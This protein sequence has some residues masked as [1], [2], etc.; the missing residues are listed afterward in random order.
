MVCDLPQDFALTTSTLPESE[1]TAVAAA[2]EAFRRLDAAYLCA[3][4]ESATATSLTIS[5][6][7]NGKPYTVALLAVDFYGNV[8]GTYF[9]RTVTPKPVTDLWED[10]HDRDSEVEG[11]CLLAQTYGDGGPL[12]QAL[13]GFRDDTLA[14]TAFGRA[15]IDAYY[16]SL[17]RLDLHGSLVLRALAAV[18][19]APVVVIALLWH[20]LTLPGLLAVLALAI[21]LRRR[22]R[23]APRRWAAAGV[24]GAA[25]AASL[26]SPRLAAADDFTPYWQT[27]EQTDDSLLSAPEINWHA[28]IR[29][30]PYIPDVDLQAGLNATTGKGPYAAMFGNYYFESQPGSDG[31][32]A[33]G[34]LVTSPR[35]M[36]C[37][38]KHDRS[39]W[40]VLPMLDLER[41]VWDGYGQLAVGGSV[42]YMQKTSYAY[43]DDTSED[44]ALRP[45]S[46]TSKNTF[47]L[48]PLAATLSYRFTLLDDLYGI[49]V[50]PYLR[51][52]LSYYAWWIN[53]PSG[54][55]S[56]VCEM[57]N[58]DGTCAKQDKA[59]GGSL[60]FQGS[61]GLAI[62]AERID[63][64]AAM[65]MR[66]SGLKH[67]GFYAEYQYAKVDGFGAASKL[68]VG[69]NTWFAGIDFEF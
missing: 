27:D 62:R 9:D 31:T 67:A 47:K 32:C 18:A 42:G 37:S 41:V 45:R 21:A 6:L 7:T 63:A 66:N 48:V 60:G 61:V 22:A 51:G 57:M 25:L 58:A 16:G 20:V 49:P 17:G 68:A 64:D 55:V 34:R 26:G 10:L 19:L 46:R 12:T 40:Q 23:L 1:G 35:G 56:K 8:V 13:R 3:S 69:D 2:P 44:E 43:L 30:G 36:V 38:E 52:G 65:S 28:G 4:V 15:L 33:K 39:V 11:G 53:G 50:I 59:Y 5:G 24:L 54:D 14:R 29:V